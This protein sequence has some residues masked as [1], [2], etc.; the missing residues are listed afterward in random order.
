MKAISCP[1]CGALIKE[2]SKH[3]AITEC[4]YCGAKV[5]MPRGGEYFLEIDEPDK[6]ILPDENI[7]KSGTQIIWNSP[8]SDLSS[9]G[10]TFEK[11]QKSNN[12]FVATVVVLCA[13]F[14]VFVAIIAGI[15]SKKKAEQTRS[16]PTP[17]TYSTPIPFYTPFPVDS[18]LPEEPE[19]TFDISYRVSWDSAID[20][21]HIELP[22]LKNAD[23]PSN[24][25]KT[26]KKTV[27]AQKIIRVKVRIDTNGEVTDAKA[28][29]GHKI[30]QQAAENAARA[31]YFTE[32]KK[33]VNIVL[34]YHFQIKQI[35]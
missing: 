32:R 29:S 24:D 7:K 11:K 18:T 20:E 6:K 12:P 21:Q 31:S 33:P 4:G 16:F 14:F 5:L 26:L 13:G 9:Y 10:E 15:A 25:L 2:V 34:T 35:E 17:R 3:Q 23:F 19:I 27:F 22:T 30:L 1:Q 8:F 28:V